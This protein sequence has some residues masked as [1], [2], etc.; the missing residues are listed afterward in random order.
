MGDIQTIDNGN[1]NYAVVAPSLGSVWIFRDFNGMSPELLRVLSGDGITT[2]KAYL[3][4][5]QGFQLVRDIDLK[6]TDQQLAA[7]F[8][9]QSE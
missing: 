8:G 9:I 2:G 6:M 1:N 4:T 3:K 7:Q 5:S